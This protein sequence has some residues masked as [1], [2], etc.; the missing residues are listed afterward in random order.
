MPFCTIIEPPLSTISVD[1][2]MLGTFAVN[3]LVRRVTNDKEYHSKTLLGVDL[4][5]RDSVIEIN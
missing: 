5:S 4:I 1:K 2:K 3:D